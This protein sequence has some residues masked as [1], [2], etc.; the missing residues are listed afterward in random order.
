MTGEGKK[1]IN[2][3]LQLLTQYTRDQ[4]LHCFMKCPFLKVFH[5]KFL[6]CFWHRIFL[7][8]TELKCYLFLKRKHLLLDFSPLDQM[9]LAL[10]GRVTNHY[11]I[12]L[13][14][15]CTH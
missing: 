8:L 1:S 5:N 7:M 3:A 6:Q 11:L 15:S 4:L 13:Y 9:N 12:H 14:L 10:Y 2:R